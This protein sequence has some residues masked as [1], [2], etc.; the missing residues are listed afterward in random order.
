[1]VYCDRNNQ[2]CLLNNLF[3]ITTG[4]NRIHIN[5]NS[6]KRDLQTVQ[7]CCEENQMSVKLKV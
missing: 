5:H 7:S 2:T 1:M 3:I 6:H 4:R